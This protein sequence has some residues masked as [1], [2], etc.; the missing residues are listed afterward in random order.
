MFRVLDRAASEGTVAR[1][2]WVSPLPHAGPRDLARD[3]R[4]DGGAVGAQTCL[5]SEG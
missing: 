2:A 1:T 3:V 5:G 4:A